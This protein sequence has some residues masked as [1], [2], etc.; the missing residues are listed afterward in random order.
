MC[1]DGAHLNFQIT[2]IQMLPNLLEDGMFLLHGC[3]VYILSHHAT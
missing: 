3:K 1:R 2:A